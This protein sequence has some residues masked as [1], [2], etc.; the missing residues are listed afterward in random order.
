MWK[1]FW[2]KRGLA[3]HPNRALDTDTLQVLLRVLARPGH[4]DTL[5]SRGLLSL[6]LQKAC[7]REQVGGIPR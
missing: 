2:F 1:G 6:P 3:K 7:A 5:D 4:R